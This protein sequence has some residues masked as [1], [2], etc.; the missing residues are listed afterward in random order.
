MTFIQELSKVR[1]FQTVLSLP[2]IS[3]ITKYIEEQLYSALK[4]AVKSKHLIRI[5]KGLYA[6]DIS[7][8][9]QEYANKLRSP[10]YISLYT[11]LQEHN[12]VFQPYSSIFSIANRSEVLQND[13][14]HYVYRKIKDS[15]LFQTFGI[16]SLNGTFKAKPERALCDKIYLDHEEYFDNLRA[17]D[18]NLMTSINQIVYQNNHFISSFIE[19]HKK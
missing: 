19:A 12:I 14:Q 2:E 9:K 1:G 6:F 5:S 17:I 18:W 7:Y 13:G 8:S 10:S 15:F 3:Y 4:Y 11:I 16:E